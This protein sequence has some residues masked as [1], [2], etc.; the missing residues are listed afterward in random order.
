MDH[1]LDLSGAMPNSQRASITSSALFIMVA[2]STEILRPM[3]KFGWAQACSGVISPGCRIALAERP[4]RCGQQQAVHRLAQVLRSS[5]R[6][7]KMAECS[8]SIGSK[9]RRAA[10]CP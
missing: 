6:H 4:A 7:W 10:P 8:L 2:E 1:H 9:V 3:E 5:G